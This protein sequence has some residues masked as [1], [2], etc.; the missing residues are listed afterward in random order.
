MTLADMSRRAKGG[1]TFFNKKLKSLNLKKSMINSRYIFHNVWW[2]LIYLSKY[3]LGV[4]Q[5][6]L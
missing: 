2:P 4:I 3:V 6:S 1:T 5:S